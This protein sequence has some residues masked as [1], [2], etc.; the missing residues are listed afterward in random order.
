MRRACRDPQIDIDIARLARILLALYQMDQHF[1]ILIK[2]I[3]W[4]E[5]IGAIGEI[6]FARNEFD[7]LS[8]LDWKYAFPLQRLQSNIKSWVRMWRNRQST[9]EAKEQ[10]FCSFTIKNGHMN[11]FLF[12]K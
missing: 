10:D 5:G 12:R 2:R 3:L 11:M 4:A 6:D 9:R 1:E 8:P 7:I